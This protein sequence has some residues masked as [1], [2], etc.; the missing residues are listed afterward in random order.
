MI[1]FLYNGMLLIS[2]ILMYF[3][4]KHFNTTKELL[5]TGIQTT[6]KVIELIRVEG[7]DGYT[8]KPVF[9]YT[10]FAGS[11]ITFNSDV[12]SRP[13][14]YKIGDQ[15]KIIHAADNTAQ[16][17]ISF[18]GLYRWTVILFA[19]ASPLLVIGGCYSLYAH[20]YI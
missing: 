4:I 8:Y 15:V 12:S 10:D 6:A 19:I 9:Q 13:A 1:E 16:K 11:E 7:D 18:W 17:V 20:G 3:G 2:V 5:N 14:A